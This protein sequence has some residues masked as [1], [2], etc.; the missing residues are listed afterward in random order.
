MRRIVVISLA[1]L[2]IGC[3]H[4]VR[5]P[6]QLRAAPV[7]APT[8]G[9]IERAM[10]NAGASELPTHC[11]FDVIDKLVDFYESHG[12][13]H[14]CPEGSATPWWADKVGRDA[15]RAWARATPMEPVIRREYLSFID[16]DEGRCTPVVHEEAMIDCDESIPEPKVITT[17]ERRK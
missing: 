10:R 13:L 12:W 6:E 2:A 1:V 17:S 5:P 8:L 9:P 11:T 3:R 7:A 14:H 15:A 16:T 4:G